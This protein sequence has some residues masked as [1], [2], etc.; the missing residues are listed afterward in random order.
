MNTPKQH[1][2][3]KD[4]LKSNRLVELAISLRHYVVNNRKLILRILLGIG[5]ALVL[6]VAKLVYDS[7]RESDAN[8]KLNSTLLLLQNTK[9]KEN[10]NLVQTQLAKLV[11]EYDGTRSAARAA[12]HL[13]V[14]QYNVQGY[15]KALQSFRTAAAD[16]APHIVGA[17]LLGIGDAYSQLNNPRKALDEG[18][19]VIIR[20]E[21]PGFVNI[22]RQ[23]TIMVLI[24][25]GRFQEAR[26]EL[27]LLPADQDNNPTIPRLRTLI[28]L[29]EKKSGIKTP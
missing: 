24:A 13:G 5:I 7:S 1:H 4:E 27:N 10:I 19:G 25:L 14:I 16:G 6:L 2:M 9:D 3:S 12:F 22:A 21:L 17:A 8:D 20:K 28:N 23:K 11:R 18:Y 15:D 26:S 29:Y